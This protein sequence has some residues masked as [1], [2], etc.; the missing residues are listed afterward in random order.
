MVFETMQAASMSEMMSIFKQAK[1]VSQ[2]LNSCTNYCQVGATAG[3]SVC[4]CVCACATI[5]SF[6]SVSTE[7]DFE[8]CLHLLWLEVVA[9]SAPFRSV[10]P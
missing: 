9:A 2:K 8:E 5:F 4:V 3:L 6:C 1:A 10:D 7:V